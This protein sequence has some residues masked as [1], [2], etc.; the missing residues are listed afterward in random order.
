MG[1]WFLETDALSNWTF[2]QYLPASENDLHDVMTKSFGWARSS[3]LLITVSH[4]KCLF[5]QTNK[6]NAIFSIKYNA[7]NI[8]HLQLSGHNMHIRL[9]F[10][11]Q[12]L[13][14]DHVWT[15]QYNILI[16][17][18]ECRLSWCW[19]CRESSLHCYLMSVV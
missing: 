12:F 14:Y 7:P 16:S 3:L 4:R 1:N 5:N 11:T 13:K 9:Y 18:A 8:L 19:G 2:K 17:T 6:Y 15:K 10:T